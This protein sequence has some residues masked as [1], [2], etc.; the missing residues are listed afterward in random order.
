MEDLWYKN[1]V[2]YGVDVESFQDSNGDGV[3]DF[4]GLIDRLDYLND[5]GVTCLWILPFYATPNRDNGYDVKDYLSVDARLGK[6]NDFTALVEAARERNIRILVDLI[7][8]HTSD[9]HP[10]FQAAVA[11]ASSKFRNFYIWTDEKPEQSKHKNI[12]VGEESGVWEYE[13]KAGAYYHHLFYNFM[14]DLNV[15]NPEV[16]EEIESIIEFWLAFGI[17]G[18]RIDAATH[19][20][21]NKGVKGT[22]IHEPAA[23]LKRLRKWVTKKDK[24]NILLGEADLE[25]EKLKPYFGNGD[26][27]NMLFNFVLDNYMFLA[28]ATEEAKPVF[29]WLNKP[30][31]PNKCQWANFLRNLD[32][33]DLERL[34]DKE[35]KQV[36]DTFAPDPNMRIFNR[37]IRRRLAPMLQNNR[38]RLEM[39]NSLLFSMP[40]AP[41]IMYGDEI[42]MGDNLD[43]PGRVSVR[44][45][46]QWNDGRNA[47]F[48]DA[49]AKKLVRQPISKGAFS[50]KKVN[51]N[52]QAGSDKSFLSWMKLLIRMRMQCKEIGNGKIKPLAASMPQVLVH[53]F[54]WNNSILVCM[55]NFGAEAC[56]FSF[57]SNRFEIRHLHDIFSDSNYQPT[58]EK[59]T[60]LEL[61]GYG[62]RWFR[63]HKPELTHAP[64]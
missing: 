28:F 16:Q 33:L 61:N 59:Q 38:K 39:A 14:P 5:L 29:D 37:G 12:F 24:N 62:Y 18:F 51:V 6:L 49:P 60:D 52:S 26:R 23:F 35:R 50:Y 47:G 9:E 4:Q 7:V 56:R 42:G 34:T 57:K 15:A 46:M 55:H 17:H 25:P 30:M 31:P 22:M 1:A 36:Y 3:G 8:H 58:S 44:T 10:W 45:P 20:L 54:E 19:L 43:L 63:V 13:K 32:E 11:D 41:V 27:M 40:G 21:E 53:S 48:S 64:I 2:F